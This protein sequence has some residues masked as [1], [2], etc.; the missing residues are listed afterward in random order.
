MKSTGMRSV[1]SSSVFV[2][3][4][5]VEVLIVGYCYCLHFT[6]SVMEQSKILL[7]VLGKLSVH[8]PFPN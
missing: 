8:Y 5:F 1:P 7:D 4:L 3:V 6:R 2:E